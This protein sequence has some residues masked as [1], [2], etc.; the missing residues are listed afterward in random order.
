MSVAFIFAS[1]A[2]VALSGALMPGPVL[3]LVVSQS[4]RYGARTG[5]LVIAGH[6]ILELALLMGLVVGLGA[7]LANET[8]QGVVALVGGIMLIVMGGTM[9]L[10]VVRRR[11]H[12]DGASGAAPLPR[13]V[14]AGALTSLANPYWVIWWATIGLAY[15]TK[16]YAAGVIGVTAFYA[17][18]VLGDLTWYSLVS[19]LIAAGRRFISTGVYR[20]T[21]A[22][23]AGFLLVLAAAFLVSGLRAL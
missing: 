2:L 11:V 14:L 18:H 5:P 13:P 17:G 21:I 9:L 10:A 6:A 15:L 19:T 20:A 1:S 4:P 3:T 8:V 12:L 16:S 7:V 23:C 22:V